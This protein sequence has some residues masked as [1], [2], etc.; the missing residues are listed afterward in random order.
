MERNSSLLMVCRFA[1]LYGKPV[2]HIYVVILFLLVRRAGELI[3]TAMVDST[4]IAE[5]SSHVDS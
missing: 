1:G 2:R 5:M 4:Q 3:S